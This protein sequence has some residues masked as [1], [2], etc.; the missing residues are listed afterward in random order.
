MSESDS[1]AGGPRR[2]TRHAPLTGR[3]R[4][5][6][7]LAAIVPIGLAV[8]VLVPVAAVTGASG[9]DVAGAAVVYG[10]L[11]GLA[12]GF[13]AVDRLQ[14]RQCPSCRRR[15]TRHDDR[16]DDCGY[17][18]VARP[19]FACDERHGI[20]LEEGLCDCG[21]RLKRLPTARGVVREVAFVLKLGAWLLVFLFGVALLLQAMDR[22]L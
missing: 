14:A 18:L 16:C 17:D 21:R 13:V 1:D 8:V 3:E 10:G 6:V 19:R 15:V 20:Y 5:L 9:A 12:A 2:V 22:Y 4:R 7:A 11:V